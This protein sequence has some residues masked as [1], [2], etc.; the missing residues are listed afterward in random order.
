MVDEDEVMTK[1]QNYPVNLQAKRSGFRKT[2]G[3]HIVNLTA[4]EAEKAIQFVNGI[5]YPTQFAD[6]S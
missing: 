2:P 1:Q 5:L 4:V 3:K 6:E